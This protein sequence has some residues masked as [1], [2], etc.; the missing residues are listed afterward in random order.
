[1][2]GRAANE[3][4]EMKRVTAMMIVPML[5]WG[6]EG[7]AMH[8]PVDHGAAGQYVAHQ[9]DDHAAHDTH[10]AHAVPEVADDHVRWQPDEPLR[11]GMR[12]MATAVGAL[13]HHEHA[14]L[15][16]VQVRKLAD[17]VNGAAAYMFANCTLEP[18]PDAALH[19]LLAQLMGGARSLAQNPDAT[20]PIAPMREALVDYVRLFD[21]PEFVAPAGG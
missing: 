13:G 20:A 18:E 5:L 12:R 1:M 9:R 10:A 16:A 7:T 15:D 3:R 11:E 6:G 21:D 14:H 19:G 4:M 2:V 8:A 17:E